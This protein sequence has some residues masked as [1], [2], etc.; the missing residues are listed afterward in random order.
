MLTGE[1]DVLPSSSHFTRSERGLSVRDLLLGPRANLLVALLIVVIG[2]VAAILHQ[3]TADFMGEDVFYADAARNLLHGFYG[4]N[5]S[6]ETTQPPGLPAILAILIRLFGYSYGV[7]VTAMA[8]FAT[9]GFLAAFE[10][11]RRRIGTA[12]AGA[13][14]IVLMTAPATFGWATRFVY[15]CFPYFFTTMAALL[16]ADEQE[17]ARTTR[18]RALWGVALALAVMA[19][20]LIA[21]GTIALLGAMLMV[22]VATAFRDRQLARVRLTQFLPA[23]VLGILVQGAW[24]NRKPAPPDWSLPGY[25]ASYLQQLKV[26]EGNHPEDGLATWRDIPTRV[27]RNVA[28]ESDLLA[29][30]VVRHGVNEQK[31]GIAL[32]PVLLIVAGWGY[33]VWVSGGTDLVA[34]YFAGYSAIYLL[35]PWTMELRFVLPVA[36]LACLYGWQGLR[37]LLD[38]SSERPRVAGVLWAALALLVSASALHSV[39][40]HLQVH[41]SDLP[42]E[43]L[44]RVCL[45]SAA[46][47]LWMSYSG[48]SLFPMPVGQGFPWIFARARRRRWSA[49]VGGAVVCALVLTGIAVDARI[50]REN[51]AIANADG[52]EKIGPSELLPVDVDAGRWLRSHTNPDAVV[53]AR[54]WPTVSHYAERKVIWFPPISDPNKLLDGILRHHVDYVVVSTR[55]NSYYLPDDEYCFDHLLASHGREFHLVLQR[56]NLRIYRFDANESARTHELPPP[57]HTP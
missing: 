36:P 24:M 28:S 38:L 33:A 13:I 15:A 16:C 49:Y 7:C 23:L 57:L 53:L 50:A 35:W 52:S 42:D 55:D 9:L 31:L 47:A 19:S 54:S 25:P 51:L 40:D 29:Q 30:I 56:P 3:R 10:L 46:V 2:I 12:L 20:L 34:W 11:L 18:S 45:M 37:N 17:K 26:K 41:Q 6:P 27:V 5:G 39:K 1:T 32:I 8:A 21:T 44:L 48:E 4:V 14:C 22:V 43:I